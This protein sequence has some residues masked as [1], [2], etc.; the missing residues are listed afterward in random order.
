[1]IAGRRVTVTDDLL[2]Q[3]PDDD[4]M[5][6]ALSASA[7]EAALFGN[8][9]TVKMGRFVIL[10][11]RGRGGMGIVY[12]AWDPQLDRR[13]ALKVVRPELGGGRR[14]ERI[15][16]EA[17]AAAR[18]SSPHIVAVHEVGESEGR[19][20]IAME[21]VE[22]KNLEAFSADAVGVE[23]CLGLY[24]QAAKGLEA[25]HAAGIVHRDFKPSNVIVSGRGDEAN[26][27]VTDFGVARVLSEPELP[28]GGEAPSFSALTVDGALLGTPA[29]MA[30][31][32][33]ERA[34]VVGPAADQFSFCV[35]LFE[36]L[37]GR[38][39]FGGNTAAALHDA[40]TTGKPAQASSD[41]PGAVLAAV[42]RGLEPDPSAR[43]P[44]MKALIDALQSGLHRRRRVLT[45]AAIS[46]A[47]VVAA[48]GGALGGAADEEPRCEGAT[49][50]W[51]ETAQRG[52]AL[53]ER[54]ADTVTL[55]HN[56]ERAV[57]DYGE[58][59]IQTRTGVCEATHVGGTQSSALLDLRVACLDQMRLE[60]DALFESVVAG[61]EELRV[62]DALARLDPPEH[63]LDATERTAVVPPSEPARRQAFDAL[64]RDLA[65]ARADFRLA[66]WKEGHA[67]SSALVE[68]AERFGDDQLRAL[69]MSM[70]AMFEARVGEPKRAAE[71]AKAALA[72]AVRADND[73]AAS[74]IATGLVYLRG[75]MLGDAAAAE[76][77]GELA[78]AWS[79]GDGLQQA[80]ALENL[81]LTAF[82]AR[83]YGLAEQRHRRAGQL[84]GSGPV[85]IRSAIN[86]AAALSVQD[87]IAKQ[88]EAG[89]LLRE[90]LVLAENTYGRDHP[91]V[92]ALLQNLSSRAPLWVPCED[93]LPMLERVLEIKTRTLGPDAVQLATSLTT[94][95]S[96][97]RRLGRAGEGLASVDRGLE[98]LTAKLGAESPKLLGPQERRIE[99][100]VAE[101]RLDDAEN[102]LAATTALSEKLYGL[103]DPENFG[104][105]VHEA[106]ILRARGQDEA[107][108]APLRKGVEMAR[109]VSDTSPWTREHELSLATLLFALGHDEDGRA[110]AAK[111]RDET[112]HP[113]A[114]ATT[115]R[116]RAS[117]L[118]RAQRVGASP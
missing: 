96:C 13:V 110:L 112:P 65:E 46:G 99:A 70:H 97:L 63:C 88:Q 83:D 87:D 59:W 36:A 28:A 118:L 19:T 58:R 4:S 24:L 43:H 94:Q 102:Q 14:D 107:A 82:V 23:R 86:L 91:S 60:A 17:K 8:T 101:G 50:A 9:T 84:L 31:E 6:F 72:M 57:E 52:E 68:D 33:F 61:N 115:L 29:Y 74:S 1:M 90:T 51:A 35:A 109:K 66:R 56:A 92:A 15:R 98:I 111:V 100:L 105:F 10:G 21:Y 34:T 2:G 71:T 117:A 25:A 12:S 85:A 3:A 40:I 5:E 39:P 49:R 16:R 67:R 93:A 78:L 48:A 103:E 73:R 37:C 76:T 30:P 45:V 38:R 95:G 108:L 44:N 18:L 20:F 55:R 80:A 47:L 89:A 53:A 62:L 114:L 26:A 79:D 116:A 42:R 32:Q 22:G 106:A 81:G 11:E 69:A 7:V 54:L 75:Y 113:G 41:A 64:Q 104:L 27:K 77:Y